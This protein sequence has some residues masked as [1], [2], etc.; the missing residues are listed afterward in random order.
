MFTVNVDYPTYLTRIHEWSNDRPGYPQ[1]R[2]R[3]ET[4]PTA[5]DDTSP[6]SKKP[7]TSHVR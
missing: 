2:Q 6:P 4:R 5:N 3:E 7:S 1:C